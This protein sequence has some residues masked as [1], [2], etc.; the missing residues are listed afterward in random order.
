MCE[1]CID[2]LYG[3]LTIDHRDFDLHVYKKNKN[4]FI[5]ILEMLG[6]YPTGKTV[7]VIGKEVYKHRDLSP[8]FS[9]E[10]AMIEK[11][12]EIMKRLGIELPIPEKSL[13][14]LN[15][16]AIW[17]PTLETF[18]VIIAINNKLAEKGNGK[19]Y[20]HLTWQQEIL[21]ALERKISLKTL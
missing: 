10:F 19:E 18:K 5:N 6:Y 3:K 17:T 20:P 2:A 12:K 1:T 16:H 7:G 13:G 8:N 11:D 4:T 14:T 15:N 21:N 9:L